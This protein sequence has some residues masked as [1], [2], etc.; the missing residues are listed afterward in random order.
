MKGRSFVC[1]ATGA[2]VFGCAT[3]PTT[4]RY[5]ERVALRVELGKSVFFEDEPIYAVFELRNA[6]PDTLWLEPFG[7]AF[8]NLMAQLERDGSDVPEF[9]FVADFWTGPGWRGVPLA[10]NG[11]FYESAVLQDRWGTRDASAP[12]VFIGHLG[13]GSY[14]ISARYTSNVP[15]VAKKSRV[16]VETEPLHFEIRARAPE[17]EVAFR[18]FER[19]RRL[20][21]D[22]AQ[23]KQYLPEVIALTERRFAAD[24]TDV[25]LPFLLRNGLGTARAIGQW[26]DSVTTIRLSRLM[27]EIAKA[28]KD[29]PSG[30]VLVGALFQQAPDQIFAVRRPLQGSLAGQVLTEMVEHKPGVP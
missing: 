17:E 11:V 22:T 15:T 2:L 28:Q 21:W 18:E 20:A 13:T 1:A 19:V 6:G 30:A 7:L 16:R 12:D 26:P 5:G 9:V 3:A 25:Y 10:P 14:E 4:P 27:I 23:R 8:L 29:Y 24:P